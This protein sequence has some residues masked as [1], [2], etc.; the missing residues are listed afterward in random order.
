METLYCFGCVVLILLFS[1]FAGIFLHFKKINNKANQLNKDLERYISSNVNLE[2]FAHLVSH[3][4]KSPL[5]S[6]ISYSDLLGKKIGKDLDDNSALYLSFIKNGAKQMNTLVDDFQDFAFISGMELHYSKFSPRELV[7]EIIAEQKLNIEAKGASIILDN[8]PKTLEAD[9][10]KIKRVFKNL[11]NNAIKFS[12]GAPRI[13]INCIKIDNEFVFSVSDNGIGIERNFFKKIFE[14][15]Q[16]LNTE[17]AFPGSGLGL[18]MSKQI[19]DLHHGKFY[20]K[21]EVNKGSTFYFTLDSRGVE[22]QFDD[23]K[24]ELALA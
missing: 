23:A 20:V 16:K 9:K 8:F 1:L 18:T 24:R 11:I 5:R 17:S 6:I 10:L 4:L 7:Q 13:E 14:S 15:F 3:D 21:S 12:T 2:E 19:I 22:I